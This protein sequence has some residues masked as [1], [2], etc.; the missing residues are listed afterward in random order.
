MVHCL[1][2]YN[3]GLYITIFSQVANV[4]WIL[5]CSFAKSCM[6][7]LTVTVDDKSAKQSIKFVPQIFSLITELPHSYALL[8]DKP[9]PLFED[10]LIAGNFIRPL[11]IPYGLLKPVWSSR[12]TMQAYRGKRASFCRPQLTVL[13]YHYYCTTRYTCIV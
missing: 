2:C 5:Q 6:N 9:T 13:I 8:A 12:K 10:E 4:K 3:Y 7:D 11:H 1:N